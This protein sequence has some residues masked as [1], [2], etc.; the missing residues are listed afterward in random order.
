MK[1]FN[2]GVKNVFHEPLFSHEDIVFAPLN[3]TLGLMKQ[4]DKALNKEG[5]SLRYICAIFPSL[6]DEKCGILDGP[7]IQT[8]IKD[9]I[10]LS[11]INSLAKEAWLEFTD[12]VEHCLRLRFLQ[13]KW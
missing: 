4:F 5:E 8:L 3:I 13:R 10:I 6:G 7:H 11:E 2:V 1:E 12:G 9:S